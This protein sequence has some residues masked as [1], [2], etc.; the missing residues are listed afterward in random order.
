MPAVLKA[1]GGKTVELHT[2]CTTGLGTLCCLEAI[3]AGMTHVNTAIP[4]LADGSSNPSIF[5]VAMNA[6][7]L[8]FKTAIDEEAAPPR[9]QA[10]H[11]L[12]QE[13]KICPSAKRRNTT[14]RNTCIKYPAA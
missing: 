10:F 6:R 11:R 8:G 2:H 3:K 14:T 5:N 1:A 13:K 7:A 4:P 9:G 12:R